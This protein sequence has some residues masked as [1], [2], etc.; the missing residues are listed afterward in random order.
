MIEFRAVQDGERI[1]DSPVM[2]SVLRVCRTCGAEIFADT[3]EGLCTACLFETGLDL[4]ARP[5]VAAEN[6][7]KRDANAAPYVKKVP[8]SAKTLAN[9]GDYELLE[10]IG[11][12]G[13]GVVYRARQKSLNR[14]VALK[15]I[16]LGHWATP[17]HLKRFR[18]EA[19][20]AASLEHPGIVPIHEVG[21][22][23]GSCYFSM[24]F[25]EGGQLDEVV[26]REPMPIRR[27]T[28][29]IANV[30]RTVHYAHEHHILHRDIKPG[31]ILLD[32][33]G[34]P[35]L[36]DFGLARL[37]ETE[38]TVTRT[39]E[40]LGTPSYM[41]PEQAVGNNAQL[42]SATDVYGLGAVL[43]QLLTGHP[44]FAGG[45]T[46]ETI[47]LVLDT[48]PRQPR[49]WTPKVDRDLS[50]IC[51]K[52]LEKDP[53]R[54]YA[55]ALALA[56]D[57]ER[58]LK[59]E[60]IRAHPTGV[61]TH[62]R[63]WVR[64]NPTGAL[65]A[66]SLVALA[67]ATA[68][69]ISKSELIQRPVTTGIAVLPFVDLSQARDQEYFCDGISEEI[70]DTLGK[71]DGLRVVG[72]AS[73]FSFK[74]N[75]ANV[76]EVGKKLHVE[77]VLE[78]SL[79]REG[80]RVRVTAELINTRTGFR[81]WS[82]TYERELQGVF[83]VQDEIT[84]SIVE[85]LKIKLAVALPVHEQRNTEVY[86]LYLQGLF[87]SNKSSEED[88]RRALRFFQGALEKDPTFSRAW[89]GIAKIWYFLAD[90]YVKPLDAYPASKEAALKAIALNEKDAEA[91]CYLSEAKRVLDWD[92]AGENAELQHALQ[93]D[94]NS[95]PAHFFLAL[96]PLFRGELKEGLQFV[97]DA[98]KLDPVSPII[99]YVATAAYLAND[100]IDD[101]INEGQRTL[102][103]DPNYFYLDS[104]LAA[105][106]RDKGNFPEAIALYA[107][108]QEATHVPSSGLAITYTRMGREMEAR[109]ILAQLLQAR[110]KRYVSAPVIAAVYVALGDKEEAFRWL[111]RA[112]AEHSGIL[113]WIAFLP[114]FRP[115]HSD[116]R[117][118]HLLRR[119]GVS[120]DTILTITETTLSES[121]DPNAQDHFTLKVG[122][123]PR[124]GTPNGHAVRILVSF[125]DLTK[126][127]KMM[128]TNAQV[129]YHWLT[130]ANGWAEAAPRFLEATYVRPKTQTLSTD[131]RRYG[132]F[133]VRVYFD[134]QLQDSRA[135]PPHLLMLFPGEDHLT[136]PPPDAPPGS[137]P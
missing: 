43:Y 32:Q 76:S 101:A 77:N 111:E 3:P 74:G 129:G 42:T 127:N 78:G 17:A 25:V 97:L 123:K 49:L 116:A 105:A 61:F 66:A 88:L 9:F 20:A 125:Y 38:S 85:A 131:V 68:W 110:E 37:V 120:Q 86:D 58:W 19:E 84:R 57:L 117:F 27:A 56:E 93:L 22:R 79:Q 75:S 73:S 23:D 46:Y 13:Q 82:E 5:S 95:A 51:L 124:P 36:T 71:V 135:S 44:P 109:N 34:E 10:E 83:A 41:A 64:R 28:E 90:V 67:I 121:T 113:Q 29:L 115:L 100:R 96:L 108:A 60:P 92:L 130:S 80:N 4:L 65:L 98:E 62:A 99:S 55:S 128:P 6:V 11:R 69:I 126:D 24:K 87:F 1:D 132:G 45:T 104:N 118:P 94:P 26:R 63:K 30:A 21:E 31:N 134:G 50:T 33:K 18:L 112:F 70:L 35:Q 91:H 103:L 137:S 54:R 52:C 7:E 47:R 8:R 15:V 136:N 107:K 59:H 72:R 14:T 119:I 53:K 102:L 106:Y 114:E 16:G 48:E 39:M 2:T 133:I 40:V 89:T 81:L 12:G 122:V